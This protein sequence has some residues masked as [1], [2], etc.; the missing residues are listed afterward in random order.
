M[1]LRAHLFFAPSG[2]EAGEPAAGIEEAE[3]DSG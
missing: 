1:G 3:S 2:G